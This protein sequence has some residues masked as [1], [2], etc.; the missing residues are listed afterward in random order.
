MGAKKPRRKRLLFLSCSLVFLV[1]VTSAWAQQGIIR[2]II[3]LGNERVNKDVIV[4]E[5][6]SKVGEAVSRKVLRDDVT[7]V[8]GLGYFRDVQ[9]DVSERPDGV[10]VTFVVMEKP[11]VEDIVISGNVKIGREEIEE[12]IEIKR[13][14][15]LDMDKVASSVEQ[16]KKLYTSKNY[17]GNEVGYTVDV[18]PGNR[19]VVSFDVKE[20][21]K[22]R[23]TEIQ[24]VGNKAVS[25]RKLRK[26]IKTKEKGWFWFVTKYGTLE[27][28]ILEVDRSRLRSLYLDRGY[29]KV[30]VNEPEITLSKDKKNIIITFKIEEG[31]QYKLG[32]LDIA[33]DILT[34]KEELRKG[35]KARTGKIYRSS[36]VQKDV[37]WLS[38]YY[39][40]KGYANVDIAPLTRLD[41]EEKLVH[42]VLRVEK[43]EQVY[44]GRIEIKGNT[45]TRD[46]VIRRELKVAEGDLYSSTALR[47]SRQ[48]VMRTQLFK[49]ADFALNP[50][51]RKDVVDVDIRVEETET[52]A[53][54]FGG[55]WSSVFGLVGVVSLS[56]R[57]LLGRGYRAYAKV[58]VGEKMGNFRL[59]FTDPRVLDTPLSAGFGLF[60]E[61]RE[62]STYQA[63]QTGGDLSLGREIT[64]DIRVDAIYLLQRVEIFDVDANASNIIKEQEGTSTTS[65]LTLRLTRNTI[66]NVFNPTKGS[67]LR[68]E[69]SI[70][71]PGG[72]NYFYRGA[73]KA[74]WYHPLIG[75]FVL[76]LRGSV[77]MVEA[78]NDDEVPLVEKFYIGGIRTLRGFEYGW[79]G[80]IDENQ[81][82][83]GAL[84]FI[85]FSTEVIYPLSKAIGLKAHVFYDAG[86]GVDDWEDITPIRHA[87]GFG[88]RWYS[89]V[90]PINIDWGYNL[91]LDE[92]RGEKQTVWDVSFGVQY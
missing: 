7:S 57:N 39:A 6:R 50:A 72:D 56:Q 85:T 62:Y 10:A 69:G 23:I 52:G 86:K 31:E 30:K 21:V 20:G 40:D 43:G 29:V 44:F 70:A 16:I 41:E 65:E 66:D 37:L 53:L 19:A 42:L 59:G 60:N 67:D 92:E 90:G 28:D 48:R 9:V 58:E 87:V 34:T 61:R 11:S 83:L 33:G 17:Y 8:F 55:G 46:K 36:V 12:V 3:I 79:A 75:D 73:V 80:P 47:K 84:K 14:A 91:D 78:Y 89:P 25:D 45:K 5:I 74:I 32:S 71:G 1:M 15:L 82:P 13:D 51:E 76:R 27:M 22:G 68:L 38:D 81:E 18:I 49:E 2:E 64:D 77:G 88:F 54:Q 26:A 24:F 63:R 4:N 35:L